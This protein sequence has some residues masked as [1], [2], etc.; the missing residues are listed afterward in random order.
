MIESTSQI[1][2]R[3]GETD[4]MGIVN[5]ANY[6][7]YYEEARTDWLLQLGLSYKKM[8]EEGIMMPLID[9]YCKY[10]RPALYDD[11]LTIKTAVKEMPS[12]KIRFDYTIYNQDG[13]LINKGY[14]Q[15]AFVNKV[16]RRPIR[17]PEYL[18]KI[19]EPYF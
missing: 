6:P 15:Q 9:L 2:V 10:H 17:I 16:N 14:S 5:N 18:K 1:R 7:T 11:V 19:M 8:E 3:Y 4:Q 13:E 12:S